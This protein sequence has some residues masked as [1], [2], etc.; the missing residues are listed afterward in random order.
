M[1]LSRAK[2]IMTS[3]DW[4]L[5]CAVGEGRKYEEIAAES[6]VPSGRLRVRVLRLR[7]TLRAV[8]I[9]DTMAA[10]ADAAA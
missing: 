1:Q 8:E 10:R 5:L 2:A 7:K 3:E 9:G 6:K 4:D